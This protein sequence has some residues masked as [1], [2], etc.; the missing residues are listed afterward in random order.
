MSNHDGNLENDETKETIVYAAKAIE[1]MEMADDL[2]WKGKWKE[3]YDLYSMVLRIEPEWVRA[4]E[5]LQKARFNYDNKIRLPNTAIPDTVRTNLSRAE[6][7]L[8]RWEIG[9]AKTFVE[10]AKSEMAEVGIGKWDE[11]EAL[12]L[13]INKYLGIEASFEKAINLPNSQIHEAIEIITEAYELTRRPKYRNKL[14]ELRK[15][16]TNLSLQEQYYEWMGRGRHALDIEDYEL[17][18]IAFENAQKIIDEIPE[19]VTAKEIID[20][21]AFYHNTET[22]KFELSNF[23]EGLTKSRRL[24]Q[25]G[26]SCTAAEI[27]IVLT[28]QI[29]QGQKARNLYEEAKELQKTSTILCAEKLAERGGY[30]RARSILEPV[31]NDVKAQKALQ[32]IIDRQ[33]QEMIEKARQKKELMNDLKIQSQVWFKLGVIASIVA[34]VLLLSGTAGAFFDEVSAG[35]LSAVSAIIPSS[36]AALFFNQSDKLRVERSKELMKTLE[37]ESLD[38]EAQRKALGLT[39]SDVLEQSNEIKTVNLKN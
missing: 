37:E 15:L 25:N 9:A 24:L 30:S 13:R 19:L 32:K 2:Y 6:S 33:N 8:S 1:I 3:A 26:E 21:K 38:I 35:I 10:Q 7:A 27:L 16:E 36:V 29:P 23:E 34:A 4:E 11:L 12:D 14:D 17:A 28:E 5:Y 22:L 39:S 20:T 18:I 31:E